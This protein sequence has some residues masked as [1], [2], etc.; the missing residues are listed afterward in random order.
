VQAPLAAG[1]V[2]LSDIELW[3]S[4]KRLQTVVAD[5]APNTITIRSLDWDRD[6][7]DI[8]FGLQEGTTYNSYV[9]FGEE[10]TA[11]VD[12]SHAKFRGLYMKALKEEVEKRGRKIDYVFVSHTEPDHSGGSHHCRPF[13]LF[14][15]VLLFS[16]QTGSFFYF[17]AHI[18]L[19]CPS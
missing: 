2:R 4:N 1:E 11:L 17:A 6:R 14:S 16:S 8:E 5:V 3:G 13:F 10:S 7:F 9:I 12:A 19:T 15:T 18:A